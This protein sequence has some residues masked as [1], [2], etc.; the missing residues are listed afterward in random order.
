M[1]VS[2][3]ILCRHFYFFINKNF[4]DASI[5]WIDSHSYL[6][7][8]FSKKKSKKKM[9]I[10]KIYYQIIFKWI[11]RIFYFIY[12][13]CIFKTISN[14]FLHIFYFWH[15][16]VRLFVTVKLP[17]KIKREISLKAKTLTLLIVI[18]SVSFLVGVNTRMPRFMHGHLPLNS[19]VIYFIIIIYSP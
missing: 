8:V 9:K 5:V 15:F 14:W 18:K 6:Y 7:Y 12:E 3:S 11:S 10:R 17:R 16:D 4:W 13:S 1:K 19:L 2:I